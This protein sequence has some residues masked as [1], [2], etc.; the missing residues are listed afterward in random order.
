M[1]LTLS[2]VA[3]TEVGLVRKTNQD[4]A[5]VSPTMLMVADGM[6]G[7]A[8]GD[9]ASAVAIN[10]LRDTDG[11]GAGTGADMLEVV[12]GAIARANDR[13]RD[14]VALDSSLDG[15]GTTV[16]G[17][18]F[19]GEQVAV[20]NIGD[21]RGY[22]LRDGVFERITRDHSW[23]QTLVDDGRITEAEALVHPHR[24]LILK[25][26]N[27]QPTHQ[28]DLELADAKVGD[29][30]LI[31]SD[32]LCGL[33]TDAAIAALVGGDDPE[34]VVDQLIRIAYDEGG[35][36]NI[37]IILADVVEDGE[38]GPTLVLGAAAEIDLDA[39]A[40]EAEDTRPL[41]SEG[42]R[43]DPQAREKAERARYQPT[44]KGRA[45]AWVKVALGIVLPVAVI[46]G[47]MFGWYSFTQ[48]KY[49][50][51]DSDDLVAVFRGVPDTILGVNLSTVLE[52]HNTHVSDLPL[53]YQEKVRAAIQVPDLESADRTTEEL[54]VLAQRCI[55]QREERARA[56]TSPSPT[57]STTPDN[58]AHPPSS[59]SPSV[60]ASPSATPSPSGEPSPKAPED[61]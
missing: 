41:P 27:G 46:G 10:E 43:P 56:T 30:Y 18:L 35:L 8:A 33:V 1:T 23:V 44:T 28:P 58:P 21:S 20:A 49:Y 22:R 48:T 42:P 51:G 19:D 12:A 59:A 37:T 29:R 55:A 6:G 32:G 57:N 14:L 36:D 26:L 39:P 45:K 50:V 60:S 24:S 4:S 11:N 31:C 3:R 47:G 54:R 16:C 52:V 2:Y 17:L 15:M 5:Y 13:I 38:P 25:V 34:Q 40:E 7:A 9:L 53:F 61:C